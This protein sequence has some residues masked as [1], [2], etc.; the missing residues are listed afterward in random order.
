MEEKHIIGID[1]GTTYSCIGAWTNGG[2][3]II[4]NGIGERTTPSVVIFD[5]KNKVYVGEET[6]NHLSKKNAVKIYE[7]K[8]LIGKKYDE[9]KDL[10]NYFPFKVERQKNGVY[11]IIKIAFDNGETAEYSPESIAS[12]IFKKLIS[13]AEIFLN[14]KINDIIISVPADFTNNQRQAI[15]FAAESIPG[16]KILQIINEPSAAALAAGFFSLNKIK[17]IVLSD[18]VK[19]NNCLNSAPHPIINKGINNEF[20]IRE[21]YY[22]L[23]FISNNIIN[24]N[25]NEENYFLVFDLGGGTYDVSLIEINEY[26]LETCATAGIQML[27]GGDF[28]YKLMEYCLDIFAKNINIDKTIIKEN[29]KS[30]ERLKIACEQTKKIL[31]TKMEDK[32]YIED[33]YK[34]ESLNVLITRAKFE[35]LCKEYFDKLIPPIDRVISDAKIDIKKIKEIILVGGSSKIPKIK[36]ILSEKFKN[37]PINDSINPDEAVAYGATLFGE[38]LVRSNNELLKN[39]EY[40]DS[41]QHSYGIE[42]ENGLMEIIL[43]RGSK[44]PTSVTRYFHNYYDDQISFDIKVYEGEN[45]YCKDNEL[46]GKFTLKNLPKMKKGELICE[47]KFG[48]DINQILKINASVAVNGEKNGIIIANDDQFKDNKKIIFEDINNIE[49]DLNEVQKKLKL[50]IIDITKS[51]NN[52]NN[53][54][55]K[56]KLILNYNKAIIEYLTFLEEKCYDIESENYLFLVEKLFKSYKNILSENYQKVLSQ[57]EKTNVEKNINIYLKKICMKNPFRLKYLINYFENIKRNISEIFYSCS[58]YCMDILNEKGKKFLNL[59]KKNSTLVAKNIFEECLSIANSNFK[60]ENILNLLQ[61]DLKQKYVGV[62][63]ECEKNIKIISAEFFNEIE[64]TKITGNLFS[65]NNNLDYD[66]LCLLSFNFSQ[67]LKKINSINNLMKNKEALETKSIC[68][69][70]IVKIEFLMKKRRLSLN[71]LSEYADESIDIVENKMGK[72]YKKKKWYN[73]IKEL[74]K[75]I[76]DEMDLKPATSIGEIENIRQEFNTKFNCGEEEF[77]KFLV[78]KYPFGEF[79]KNYNIIEEYRKNKKT[80]LKKL[81][82]KYRNYDNPSNNLSHINNELTAKKEIIHEYINNILNSLNK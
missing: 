65:N 29:Y 3:V 8:R 26:I 59:K 50:N 75:N 13:N 36:Q 6:L 58:I 52:I 20:N 31:S 37:I 70:N 12:L 60:D 33:F 49:I 82:I 25:N 2:I 53:E 79:N 19:K 11:P 35:S 45:K 64:N 66:N 14:H 9:I 39:F 55:D 38:K 41:T 68:L 32:I 28:D 43:P 69:A 15:K 51:F 1:F 40:I 17:N 74:K 48:I 62:K 54:D 21:S 22:D 78:E 61:N 7:I 34:E 67:S 16:I 46:L 4:P 72:K 77:L 5:N 47:V 30:M 63:E 81:I 42:V 27:G 44:Y 24:N 73:E 71:N 80:L 76:K 57:N 23:S 56:F 18:S 10:I